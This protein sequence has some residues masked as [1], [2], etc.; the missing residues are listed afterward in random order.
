MNIKI[1]KDIEISANLGD[2]LIKS[3]GRSV[4]I[5]FNRSLE[6]VKETDFTREENLFGL[7]QFEN[8]FIQKFGY[9]NDEGLNQHSYYKYGLSFYHGHLVEESDWIKEWNDKR[10]VN[11]VTGQSYLNGYN[12]YILTFQENTFECIAKK[13]KLRYYNEE[14]QRIIQEMF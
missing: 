8:V 3:D 14:K 10:S 7:I 11:K 5:L 1:L 9:P 4:K 2:I 6:N 12:H 13:Y